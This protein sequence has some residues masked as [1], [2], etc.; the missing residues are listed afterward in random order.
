[1]NRVGLWLCYA[2]RFT[3]KTKQLNTKQ[4]T[5]AEII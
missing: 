1:M 3:F 4:L 5:Y 2:S